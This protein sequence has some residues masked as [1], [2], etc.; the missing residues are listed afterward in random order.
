MRAVSLLLLS[1]FTLAGNSAPGTASEPL[2]WM[3]GCWRMTRGTTVIDE[4]W[5]S[6]L[7]G[8]LLGNGR[9]VKSGKVQEYEFIVLRI[10]ATG[11]TYE[12]HPS[13]QDSA[14]FTSRTA[15]A[16]DQ[17][18][19]ENPTHDFPQ[20]VGYRRVSADSLLAWIEGNMGNGNK[21]IEFPYARVGCSVP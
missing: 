8:M 10:S 16:G 21:K 20:K 1:L 9:T 6:P 12:A 13:G 7:G 14:T 4:Q 2:G 11:A 3:S 19:F 18:V 15:P 17:V 5:L